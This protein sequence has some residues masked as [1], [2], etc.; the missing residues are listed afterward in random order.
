MPHALVPYGF[1]GGCP[2]YK[3]VRWPKLL[4][5]LDDLPIYLKEII[6]GHLLGDGCIKASNGRNARLVL[7]QGLINFSYFMYLWRIMWPLKNSLEI[8]IHKTGYITID[9][10]P[11]KS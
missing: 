2:S 5:N 10:V 8:G 4:Y 11:G 6:L 7:R 9:G 3:T 1:V